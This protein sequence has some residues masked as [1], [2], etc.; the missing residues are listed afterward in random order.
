MSSQFVATMMA[1]HVLYLGCVLL[2]SVLG[3]V[4]ASFS[5]LRPPLMVP[6]ARVTRCS[7]KFLYPRAGQPTFAIFHCD[8]SMLYDH[9]MQQKTKQQKE[10][11]K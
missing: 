10:K 1:R 7:K 3:D 9:G 4:S 2:V 8:V 11:K 5:V 6:S